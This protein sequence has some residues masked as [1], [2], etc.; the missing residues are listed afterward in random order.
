MSIEEEIEKSDGH[1]NSSKIS[2]SYNRIYKL[3]Y[4]YYYN[5]FFLSF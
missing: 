1:T 3:F 4:Y 2:E 5:C